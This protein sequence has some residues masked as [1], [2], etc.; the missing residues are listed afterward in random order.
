MR[1]SHVWLS[2]TLIEVHF[3]ISMRRNKPGKRDLAFHRQVLSPSGDRGSPLA[4]TARSRRR[5]LCGSRG[6]DPQCIGGPRRSSS[7][8]CR[9][10]RLNFFLPI[11]VVSHF[12][13]RGFQLSYYVTDPIHVSRYGVYA[14][15]N[16]GRYRIYWLPRSLISVRL[17]GSRSWWWL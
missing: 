13:C 5:T 4:E 10:T 14:G 1:I 3:K 2:N 6:E 12:Q 16:S 15:N 8:G 11:L 17:R 7:L 9:V